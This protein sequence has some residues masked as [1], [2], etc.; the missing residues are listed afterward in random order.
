LTNKF[1]VYIL[2]DWQGVPRYIGKGH[3]N[4]WLAHENG[5]DNVRLKEII[6]QTWIMLG[7]VPKIKVQE[8]M[9]EADAFALEVKLIQALGIYPD[10]PLYNRTTKRNGPSSER[11]RNWHANKTPEQK[12]AFSKAVSEGRKRIPKEK[13]SELGRNAALSVPSEERSRRIKEI[14]AKQ[15]PERR[16]EIGKK[17]RAARN[18]ENLGKRNISSEELGR[19]VKLGH[20]KRSSEERKVA[21][22][23]GLAAIK[24]IVDAMTPEQRIKRASLGGKASGWKAA[25]YKMTTEQRRANSFKGIANRINRLNNENEP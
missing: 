10:G 21:A 18:P 16:S 7:E 2:F 20:S 6:E 19:R 22:M 23:K 17:A 1:Y 4:R 5:T 24:L 11:M 13:L 14:K 3:S 8:D 25:N 12:A 15:T 9:L